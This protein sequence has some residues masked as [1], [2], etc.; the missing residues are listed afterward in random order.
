ANQRVSAFAHLLEGTPYA[1]GTLESS[2]EI[3]T[4]NLDGMDCT[5]FVE[6]VTALAMTLEERRTAWQDFVYNL[7]QIR[8]RQ[9]RPDG[10][11]SRLHYMSDWIVDNTHRGLLTEITDRLPGWSHQVKTLDY[12]SRHRSAYP[13]LA[14]DETFE[15]I[16]SVEVGFRSHRFPLLRSS[17][18]QTKKGE[19]LLK[20]G[21]ILMFTTKTDGLDV[22]HTGIA[23]IHPDGRVHLIHASSTAGKVIDD[24]LPLTDYL[25]KNHNINGVRV[26]R[27]GNLR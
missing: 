20:E 16:K 15:K 6:T 8:Y 10:Y 11:A 24:P 21:D 5:T 27:L 3:L 23:T 25:R 4:V 22:S 12:M 7:G 2:P 19:S 26:V 9:G 14:D 1:A 17:L 13:A 18:M